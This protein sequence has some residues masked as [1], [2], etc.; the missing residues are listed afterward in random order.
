MATPTPIL[1][2]KLYESD[3]E[4]GTDSS[5]SL[6]DIANTG[7]TSIVDPTYG[8]VSFFDGS[9]ELVLPSASIPTNLTS[10]NPRSYSY[11]IKDTGSATG[12]VIHSNGNQN[13]SGRRFRTQINSSNQIAIAYFN[14]TA[15]V[16]TSSL[17]VDQW[18]HVVE[19]FTGTVVTI[20]IDNVSEVTN[21]RSLVTQSSTDFGIGID[22]TSSNTV[23]FQ[24][25]LLDFRAYDS[26]LT[27]TEISDIYN[28]GPDMIGLEIS[29]YTHVADLTWLAISGATNYT[30]TQNV[31]SGGE[32]TLVDSSTELSYTVGD[33]VPGSSYEFKLYTDLDLVTEVASVEETS[34][35]I[36]T[37]SVTS[38]IERFS[39]DLVALEQL[40][41]GSILEIDSTLRDILNTGDV[42]VTDIGETTF[43]QEDET[44]TIDSV[45][46]Q[47]V[48][49]PFQTSVGVD[50]EVT[51]TLPESSNNV[52]Y[53]H[54]NNTVISDSVEYP[55]GSYYI[56]GSYKV[57]VTEL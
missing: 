46:T 35:A 4:I 22:P 55:V 10:N 32:T 14:L 36:D 48:L 24:G 34:P 28:A 49:L 43:V 21:S 6:I 42:V 41:S 8:R 45:G 31:D 13:A 47:N 20:Y 16:T 38:I 15:S 44:L 40:S 39:N 30:I 23:Q 52:T 25:C 3:S 29:M 37:S 17:T 12:A 56:S 11:W 5:S 18:Y 33:I 9:S 54:S 19:T 27:T 2:Y 51:I 26:A 53:N 1:H 7:V 50:Q 57:T